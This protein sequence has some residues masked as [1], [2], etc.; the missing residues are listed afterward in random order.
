[1]INVKAEKIVKEVKILL[2]QNLQELPLR[3][4]IIRL[5]RER[6][7]MHVFCN[8][9]PGPQSRVQ[10]VESRTKSAAVYPA[11]TGVMGLLR[12]VILTFSKK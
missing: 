3:I 2:L 5:K 12:Y 10:C 4:E 1:M 6:K 8:D 9:K 11:K 7:P